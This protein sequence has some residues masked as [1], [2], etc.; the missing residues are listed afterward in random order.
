MDVLPDLG[1]YRRFVVAFSGGKDSLASLLALL[2][3]GISPDRIELHHHEVDGQ[4]A[5]LMDWPCTPAYVDAL[6]R[7][8]GIALYRSWRIGG[9]A[10][11]LDRDCTATAPIAFETPD[12]LRVAGGAGPPGTR[13]LFP[14]ISADLRVRWCS[15][16]LKIDVLAAAIRNQSRFVEGKTL[17]VTGE[18]AAESPGRA[19]YATFEPHRTWSRRRHVDHW[20]PVHGWGEQ[21][22]WD[23][24]ASAR[25]R[26]HP[27]YRLGWRRLSCRC[28]IFG[29]P[30]Q[31]ATLRLIFPQ[32]F[33]R[34][35]RREAASSRTIHRA[36]SVNELADRGRPYPAASAHPD[37]RAQ[38]DDP[39]WQLPITLDPWSLPAGAFGE[40]AGPT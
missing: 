5:T 1:A 10:R 34:V 4:G 28:C 39:V 37:D 12:G 13:G 9:F 21:R 25:I 18:R 23:I 29:T 8:F 40:A 36:C 19:R 17:V 35:A 6:A 30:D 2:E 3:H 33:E 16:A 7:H 27:A 24:I 11:E 22:V 26:L 32:A 31:W 38:A 14:Q 20:R 15:P